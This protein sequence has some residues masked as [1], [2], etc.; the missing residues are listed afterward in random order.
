MKG[1]TAGLT[2]LAI[3]LALAVLLLTNTITPVVSGAVFAVGLAAFG[4][5][6]KGFKKK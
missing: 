5:I 6:S 3:C 4:W 2:F 1:K